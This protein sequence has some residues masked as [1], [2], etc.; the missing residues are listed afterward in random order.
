[1]FRTDIYVLRQFVQTFLFGVL[2]FVTIYV[3]VD[4]IENLE[5]YT[6]RDL[7]FSTILL[8]YVYYIP[9]IIKLV[10]PIGMLLAGLFTFGKLDSTHEL[11]AMRAAGR[12]IRRVA[13]PLL[14][15]G[16]I[17]SAGLVYFNGWVVPNANAARFEIDRKYLGR[18]MVGGASNSFLRVSPTLNLQVDYYD[19][20]AGMAHTVS[21]ER[22]DSNALIVTP[23]LGGE[24]GKIRVVGSDSM[25][26]MAIVERIDAARMYWD[27]TGGE[28]SGVWKMFDGIARNMRDPNRIVATPFTEREIPG[29]AI[30][31]ESLFQ[32]QQLSE[33]MTAPEVRQKIV[34]EEMGG[35]DV[36]IQWVNYYAIFA[37]PFAAFIVVLF[38]IPFSS[39]QRKGGAAV[40]IAL[41]A[42]ISA[43]YL[44]FI[45]VSKT[46]SVTSDVSPVLTA[47]L[48][49]GLFFLVGL[50]N[51]WRVER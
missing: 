41:T 48:A 40:P 47:W 13:A 5:N 46:L 51:L 17:V 37:Y 43:V 31:P 26:T 42:L 6:D 36:T 20:S 11:T 39:A 24:G 19:Q 30:S 3:V 45:E 10:A 49:N 8:Y 15:F 22:I 29:L 27:S 21:L 14:L 7:G 38:G 4:L 28:G 35:R 23:V 1:M 34:R 16:L 50:V 12:S 25:R 44:I 33:E 9:E 18:N 32:S 2:A